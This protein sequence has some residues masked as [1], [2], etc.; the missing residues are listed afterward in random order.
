MSTI[1]SG[2]GSSEHPGNNNN[3]GG[4]NNH[5]NNI[6]SDMSHTT[7]NDRKRRR[8]NDSDTS[9]IDRNRTNGSPETPTVERTGDNNNDKSDAVSVHSTESLSIVGTRENNDTD[10]DFDLNN[11]FDQRTPSVSTEQSTSTTINPD[12]ITSRETA[13]NST[14]PETIDLDT[15]DVN[16]TGTSQHTDAVA[17]N[18]VVNDGDEDDLV[19]SGTNEAVEPIELEAS[20]QQVVDI[21]DEELEKDMEDRPSS[22]FKAATEYRCPICFDP[23]ETALITACGHVFCC[24]CLFHMVNSSRTNRSSGHCALCRS[25][26]KFRDLRLVVMRKK[27]IRKT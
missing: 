5:N 11:A 14:G 16:T 8:S 9:E 25:A 20:Q 10:A 13:T 4:S 27:R 12:T 17:T 6:S 1:I 21:S 7:P 15:Q 18:D 19:I 26:V 22:E 3:N 23:P 2:G 24:D